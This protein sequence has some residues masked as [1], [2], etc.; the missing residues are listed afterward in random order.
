MKADQEV[1]EA[2]DDLDWG[3]VS[4]QAAE[5]RRPLPAR[6]NKDEQAALKLNSP[7]EDKAG[8]DE[9]DDWGPTISEEEQARLDLEAREL[10]YSFG[11]SEARDL[12]HVDERTL[13]DEA[14]RLQ[15]GSERIEG[16]KGRKRNE[17]R[18]GRP[19]DTI[20][21]LHML[22]KVNPPQILA[23]SSK[24]MESIKLN[25]NLIGCLCLY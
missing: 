22:P 4:S 6:F 15:E 7:E 25:V 17:R 2:E 18:S 12:S 24:C 5:V 10:A 21:P 1:Q 8:H 13:E 14:S 23:P 19:K 16:R 11:T 20:I 9:S 3:E